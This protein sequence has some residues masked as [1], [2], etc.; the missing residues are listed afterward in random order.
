M[1]SFK[2]KPYASL[3]YRVHQDSR[4]SGWNKHLECRKVETVCGDQFESKSRQAHCWTVMSSEIYSVHLVC[5]P[6]PL[7]LVRCLVLSD[8]WNANSEVQSVR[9]CCGLSELDVNLLFYSPELLCVCWIYFEVVGK[10]MERKM[11]IIRMASFSK[12]RTIPKS[13]IVLRSTQRV[14]QKTIELENFVDL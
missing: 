3:Y 11:Q 9:C 1:S 2:R 8:F 4:W 5:Q 6:E 13:R 12:I 7:N 14:A 10:K